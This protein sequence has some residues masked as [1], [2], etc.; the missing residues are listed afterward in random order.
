MDKKFDELE[1]DLMRRQEKWN[2]VM[3]KL[4]EKIYGELKHSVELSAEAV[5]Y[6]QMIIEER[7]NYYYKLY[8][9]SAKLKEVHKS[10]FEY[11][12]QHYQI[13][14]N[15]TEKNKLIESDLAWHDAKLEFI[16][17]YI[18]FLTES[19][20]SVDHVIWSVKNKIDFYN[21]SGLD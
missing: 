6:R 21:I 3:E 18:N 12:S 14:T 16:Q 20:K 19:I 7:T 9:L 15:S 4:S 13:K 11:Y 17:T 8:R 1:E 10:K 5:S 2:I